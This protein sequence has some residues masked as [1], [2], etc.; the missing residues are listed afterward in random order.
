VSTST[1]R[2]YYALWPD[3]AARA[4]LCAAAAPLAALAGGRAVLAEDLHLT[5][6]FVGPVSS[7]E[8]GA[9]AR[10]GTAVAWPAVTLRFGRAEWWPA[11]A[12]LVLVAEDPPRALLEARDA[13]CARLAARGIVL[14]ARP[15]RA[16]VTIARNVAS[17]PAAGSVEVEW[18]ARQVALVESQPAPDRSRYRP[19]ALWEAPGSGAGFHVI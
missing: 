3:A 2:V 10:L 17:A 8:V 9:L 16:H 13:L 19:L 5:L 11:S 12:A 18:T 6:A 1:H 4:T 7:A 14:D 15:F